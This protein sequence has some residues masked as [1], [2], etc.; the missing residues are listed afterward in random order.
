[1]R[2]LF[3]LTLLAS[4]SVRADP[5]TPEEIAKVQREQKAADAEVEK[6]YGNKKP[7]ELSQDDRRQMIKDKSEAERNVLDKNNIDAKEFARTQARQS[8]QDRAATKAAAEK[9]DKQDAD[10]KAAASKPAA[11]K[12]DGAAGNDTSAS[13]AE[14]A[15]AADRAAGYKKGK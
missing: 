9:L 12:K 5:P 15:A 14:E 11:G 1:M 2:T 3:A 13:D 8:L 10:S 4:L 7:S 6:K